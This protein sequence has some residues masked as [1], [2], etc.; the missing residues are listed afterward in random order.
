MSVSRDLGS[1]PEVLS[2][3][4][5]EPSPAPTAE[6]LSQFEAFLRILT[7]KIPSTIENLRRLRREGMS[8]EEWTGE[9]LRALD[10]VETQSQTVC[11]QCE[12]RT[13]VNVSDAWTD[14]KREY[15]LQD[16]LAKGV[17]FGESCPKG[18]RDLQQWR[19]DGLSVDQ[20]S[21][22]FVRT[23]PQLNISPEPELVSEQPQVS[24]ATA[25]VTAP[26]RDVLPSTAKA[27]AL[28]PRVSSAAVASIAAVERTLVMAVVG[29]GHLV[30]A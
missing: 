20:V 23:Y 2:A 28:S 14:E 16:G 26:S 6:H 12:C 4:W 17:E 5:S 11:A 24:S 15:A 22:K 3:R 21:V 1:A 10:D 25:S 8:V 18:A 30:L 29:L 19:K 13:T 7:Q 9:V 27:T